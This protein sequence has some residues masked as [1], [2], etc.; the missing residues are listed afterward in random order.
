MTDE[1]PDPDIPQDPGIP[2]VDYAN[3]DDTPTPDEPAPD[4][5]HPET[6]DEG[7]LRPTRGG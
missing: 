5:G 4:I 7:A 2:G 3:P 6:D 1:L